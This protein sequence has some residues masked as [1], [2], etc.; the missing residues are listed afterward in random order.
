MENVTNMKIEV[1]GVA[2]PN[3]ET[4]TVNVL[5]MFRYNN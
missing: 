4:V 1:I 3:K 5:R 2:N